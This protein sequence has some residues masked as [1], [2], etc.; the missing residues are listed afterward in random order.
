MELSKFL[1]TIFVILIGGCLLTLCVLVIIHDIMDD[2]DIKEHRV[3]HRGAKH[4]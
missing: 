2:S 4:E 1:S 3:F